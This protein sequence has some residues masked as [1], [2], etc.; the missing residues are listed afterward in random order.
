VSRIKGR[1]HVSTRPRA[2]PIP[3]ILLAPKR[4][5]T[6]VA[7]AAE[8]CRMGWADPSFTLY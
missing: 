5:S 2:A 7:N 1:T 3:K 4:A 8:G 6:H